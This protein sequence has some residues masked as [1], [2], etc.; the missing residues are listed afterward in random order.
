MLL[1]GMSLVL[2]GVVIVLESQ[3][4]VLAFVSALIATGIIV[5]AMGLAAAYPRADVRVSQRGVRPA[6][7]ELQ[8]L[9][10]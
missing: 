1:W 2:L 5:V 3:L 10:R 4:V 8:S 6:L 9:E 7:A